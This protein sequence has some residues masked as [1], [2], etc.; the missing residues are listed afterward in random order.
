MPDAGSCAR[1]WHPAKLAAVGWSY[2]GYAALQGA[3]VDPGLFK[4]VV[5]VAPVTDLNMVKEESRGW[6]NF[7]LTRAFVGSGA[8]VREGSPAQHAD[9]I[10]APVLL[11]H[12]D[13]DSNVEISQSRVMASRLRAKRGQVELVEYP[14]LDHYLDAS[15]ART[16]MLRKTDEFLRTA[17][18]DKTGAGGA[19]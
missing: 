5:A 7:A 19:D 6:S 8:H 11:F 17:W 16:A 1:A 9:K 2:G 10:R 13:R 18:A 3:V 4:A 14:G 12:G 15:A